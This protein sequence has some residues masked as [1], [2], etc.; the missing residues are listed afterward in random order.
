VTLVTAEDPSANVTRGE[1]AGQ[2]AGCMAKLDDV[3]RR[4]VTLRIL[5]EHSGAEAA[6][7]LGLTPGH[8]AVLLHRAKK[9]LERCMLTTP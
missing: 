3:P 6:E 1:V 8:V 7:A 2:L 4:I 9:D 5:E